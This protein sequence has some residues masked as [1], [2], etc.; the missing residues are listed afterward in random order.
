M[1]VKLSP[2]ALEHPAQH[3]LDPKKLMECGMVSVHINM[4]SDMSPIG[5]LLVTSSFAGDVFS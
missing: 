1:K 3:P 5:D 4:A 2:S